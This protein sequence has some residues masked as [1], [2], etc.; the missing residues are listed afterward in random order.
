MAL[1]EVPGWSVPADMHPVTSQNARKRKRP[2]PET[3]SKLQ[4]AEVNVEK[5]MKSIDN[6]RE[7]GNRKNDKKKIKVATTSGKD[8]GPDHNL[9]DQKTHT[10]SRSND[11][12]KKS[13]GLKKNTQEKKSRDIAEKKSRPQSD[14][15]EKKLVEN[16][17]QSRDT[18]LTGLQSKM[19]DRL[20]GSKFRFINETLYT[21][22][23]KD[24]VE[25]MHNNPQIFEEYHAGFR[26]QVTSWPSNPVDYYIN[27]L[28]TYK[29]KTVVVDLGCGDAALARSLI[30]KGF[31]VL[32]F[33]LVSANFFVIATD[34]CDKLP[35][36]GSETNEEGHIVDV[37]VCSLSLMSKNWLKCIREARR[38]LKKGGELKI[39]EVTSRF[40]DPDKFTTIIRE[41]GFELVSKDE[42]NS[43]FSL[44]EFKKSSRLQSLDDETWKRI[45][46]QGDV[47]QPCEYKRR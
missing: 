10:T 39:A 27:M 42:S 34:I 15:G 28:S 25:L 17:Q 9:S 21:S 8:G 24:A 2:V 12:H 30:P 5:L 13:K 36:P 43:H 18:H 14:I 11:E 41:V 22:N 32:S 35:L 31:T 38:I 46:N 29:K 7:L 19:K 3:T 6:S 40:V 16:A 20:V 4:T 37:V 26:H 1:F 23:S 44:F 47:L 33:D 45:L